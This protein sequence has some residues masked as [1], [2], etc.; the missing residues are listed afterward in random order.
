MKSKP[1]TIADVA[2]Q[3]GVS[4]MTV[5]RVINEAHKVKED[6]RKTV[7]AAIDELNYKPNLLARALAGNRAYKFA[8]LYANPSAFYLSELLVGALEATSSRGHQLLVQKLKTDKPDDALLEELS[9]VIGPFD[10]VIVP[11]PISDSDQVR[12]YLRD[13][14]VPAIYLSGVQGAGRN[15]KV[16]IDDYGAAKEMARHFTALGHKH[17]GLITGHPNQH[18]SALRERG[19]RDGLAEAGVE[20]VDEMVEQ[21]F[22]TYDSGRDAAE[23]LLLRSV[24]PTAIFASNDDM[25]AAAVAFAFAR[26]FKVPDDISIAGFDDSPIASAIFPR[27]TTIKQPLTEMAETAIAALAE[28]VDEGTADNDIIVEGDRRRVV[29]F[30]F[31]KGLSTAPAKSC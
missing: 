20:L 26:G 10:G 18:S 5:S 28:L 16:C 12:N 19:F 7:R 30:E 8:L 15:A 24:P 29:G 21:G 27:L 6:T 11:P 2:R 23:K 4:P 22:F 31:I 25:A 9:E 3:A 14:D 1:P 13:H 17:I